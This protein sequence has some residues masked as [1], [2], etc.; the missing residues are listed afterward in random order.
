MREIRGRYLRAEGGCAVGAGP[1]GWWGDVSGGGLCSRP[2]LLP[3]RDLDLDLDLRPD[4][5]GCWLGQST[6]HP[7]E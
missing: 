3:P 4:L 2:E 1:V 5:R 6:H 7:S